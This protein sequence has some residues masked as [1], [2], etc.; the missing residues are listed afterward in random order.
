LLREPVK[1]EA[2]SPARP[3]DRGKDAAVGAAAV[4]EGSA[5]NPATAARPARLFVGKI[6]PGPYVRLTV[7]DSGEGM[8]ASVLSHIF[9]PFYTT[10]KLGEASGLGLAVV[11]GIVTAHQGGI[12]V[13]ST[14]GQGTRIEV[15]LPRSYR[16]T[17]LM[18]EEIAPEAERRRVLLAG[19]EDAAMAQ[20]RDAL[21]GLGLTVEVLAG[22]RAA[23]EAFRA[24]PD[25]WQAVVTDQDLG[26]MTG[27]QLSLEIT[28]IRGEVPIILCSDLAKAL[29]LD[30]VKASGVTEFVAK[31]VDAEELAGAVERVMRI[32]PRRG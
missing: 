31:P 27:E 17:E 24:G 11:H 3:T 30:R 6:D 20:A 2:A 32:G 28:R 25:R 13:S 21:E 4:A 29:T 22:G 14:P 5:E 26:D 8:P 16:A 7:A 19:A 9:E 18:S 23:L 1:I 12:I 10:R 15:L